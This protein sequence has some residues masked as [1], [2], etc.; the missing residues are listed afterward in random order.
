M[1]RS[2]PPEQRTGHA[3]HA[4]TLAVPVRNDAFVTPAM[5]ASLTN[6]ERWAAVW[7]LGGPS[8]AYNVVAD[9]GII[10]RYCSMIERGE[11]LLTQL[12]SE[13]WTTEGASGQTVVHPVAKLLSDVE[14]KIGPVE[15]ALGLSPQAR[16]TINISQAAAR[17]VLDS[18]LES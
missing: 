13:G 9:F 17:S 18:W 14:A 11:M 10:S 12:N 7:A 15:A 6:A 1:G 4:A 8:G 5:P 2:K 3:K 16:N